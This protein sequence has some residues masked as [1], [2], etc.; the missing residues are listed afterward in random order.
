MLA[1]LARHRRRWAGAALVLGVAAGVT[2]IVATPHPN[3]DVHRFMQAST[4][5]L[6]HG[7]YLY[8]QCAPG[9]TGIQCG[10]P[11]LP[12]GSVL[13]LPSRLLTGDVR[14]GLVA[15]LAL[16]VLA[17]WRTAG[18]WRRR[19]RLTLALPLLLLVFPQAPYSLLQDWTEPLLVAALVLM[20]AAVR[21]GRTGWATV[22]FA[23]GLATKQHMVL[24][25]PLAAAWPEFGL[26]RTLRAAALG[27]LLVLPWLAA[28]PARFWYETVTFN[29]DYRSLPQALDLPALLVRHGVR[30]GFAL[31][32]AA[33]GG[34]YLVALTR[35][36]RS[37]AGFAAGAGL[38]DLAV[39]LTNKQSFFNH[40]TLG[41]AGLVLAAVCALADRGADQP[42]GWAGA[43][44]GRA[45]AVL[46]AGSGG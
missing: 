18:G 11:Y 43:A 25:V 26:R 30:P 13:L 5:G 6:L 7:R 28:D 21:S 9:P 12:W 44:H 37:A 36:P 29:L 23:V 46:P 22:A 17:L 16:A 33:A 24:F 31:T 39:D 45:A 38:V 35:L 27:V 42:G 41:M 19:D 4:I 8:T 3:I 2:R 15:A 14:Y 34:A 1:G 32:L 40:Y 10:Y 20:V